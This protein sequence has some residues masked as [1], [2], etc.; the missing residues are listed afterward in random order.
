[1]DFDPQTYKNT[2]NYLTWEET[3]RF[4]YYW[5]LEQRINPNELI[6][7]MHRVLRQTDNKN[8]T[9]YF[10]GSSNAGKTYLTKLLIPVDT[11]AGYHTTSKEFPF[12]D[13]VYQPIIL[14]NELT[15]ESAAKAE[16]YKNV[17]GVEPTQ[18]N[19]KNTPSQI[20]T[21]RPVIL[22]TNNNI[23]KYVSNETQAFINRCYINNTWKK[24]A[25]T[26]QQPI[27]EDVTPPINYPDADSTTQN[28]DYIQLLDL[29]DI[30]PVFDH[31]PQDTICTTSTMP[32]ANPILVAKLYDPTKTPKKTPRLNIYKQYLELK[33]KGDI[34][35]DEDM[36]QSPPL[37]KYKLTK[38]DEHDY[39]IIS[40]DTEEEYMCTRL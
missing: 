38:D 25:T 8:N 40:S 31:T 26:T 32:T 15:I 30:T 29:E 4:F 39:I 36:G 6:M 35:T 16:L 21:R 7:D 18:I 28:V 11:I 34:D 17:L 2:T 10:Q 19:I 1:M 14:I 33:R 20:M 22:T 12:G 9:L 37:K 27:Y 24:A 13:A 5:C 3:Q 23:W